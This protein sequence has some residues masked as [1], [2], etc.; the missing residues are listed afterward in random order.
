MGKWNGMDLALPTQ[1]ISLV[2]Q[3]LIGVEI[4]EGNLLM[5]QLVALSARV[6]SFYKVTT[7]SHTRT[8]DHTS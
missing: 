6:V 8:N 4:T 7:L 5:C 2:S 1:C 3:H